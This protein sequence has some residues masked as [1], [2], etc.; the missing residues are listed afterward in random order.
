MDT[1]RDSSGRTSVSAWS[2]EDEGS[3]VGAPSLLHF[4][5]KEFAKFWQFLVRI[6]YVETQ[7]GRR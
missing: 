2:I 7:M 3:A 5:E 1:A 6:R 4:N